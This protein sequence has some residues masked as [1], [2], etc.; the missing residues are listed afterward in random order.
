MEKTPQLTCV[1][2]GPIPVAPDREGRAHPPAVEHRPGVRLLALTFR[3]QSRGRQPRAPVQAP[4][5]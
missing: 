3:V 1:P 2:L 4:Y 5:L